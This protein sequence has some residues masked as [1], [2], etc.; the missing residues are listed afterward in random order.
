[1]IV[2]WLWGLGIQGLNGEP[3]GAEVTSTRGLAP[4]TWHRNSFPGGIN[5][6][7]GLA[8]TT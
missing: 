4:K 5:G 3:G 8:G 6:E 2:S 7:P 1:M